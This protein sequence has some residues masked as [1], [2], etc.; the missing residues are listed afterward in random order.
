VSLSPGEE[1]K[2]K[3][4]PS[5][6][7]LRKLA[8]LAAQDSDAVLTGGLRPGNAAHRHTDSA[9]RR[10][11]AAL[12]MAR[13]ADPA[14]QAVS[15]RINDNL[16][17]MDEASVTAL[18]EI[19][20]ALATLRRERE[21][22]LEQAYRDE[23]SRLVFMTEDGT[24]AYYEDGTKVADDEFAQISEDLR[25]RPTWEQWQESLRKE[26]ELA[27][28]RD[29][30]HQ[31][32]AEREQLR[33][34]LAEGRI[35]KEEAEQRERELEEALPERVRAAYA[36]QQGAD[37]AAAPETELSAEEAA[38]LDVRSAPAAPRVP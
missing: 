5:Q 26:E 32:D 31:H 13:L 27:A 35:S 7:L 1:F 21:R 9:G 28:E 8:Y 29:L 3:A 22:M 34:D 37:N 12:Q 18:Q 19:E 6:E 23:H 33:E 10:T 4:T 36:A 25:G 24:G 11:D 20:E 16:G 15:E 14:Y 30:I 38:S 2:I 17:R